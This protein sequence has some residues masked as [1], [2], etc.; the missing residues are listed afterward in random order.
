MNMQPHELSPEVLLHAY[1]SGMFPMAV[2]ELGNSI[3][4]FA[5]DPR[6]IIPLD[7][8]HVSKSLRR[9]VRKQPFEVVSDRDFEA[10]IRACAEPRE[11]DSQDETW[12]SEDIIKAY[13][14]L[15]RLGFAHSVECYENGE[16]VGGLYGVTLGG[17]FFGES[18]FHKATDASKIALYHLVKQM[19]RL[20]YQ[21][22]DVQYTTDHLTR[23]GAVEITRAEYEERLKAAVELPVV[24]S[25]EIS[26]G[27]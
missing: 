25:C 9:K 15:H 23:L 3:F 21:L 20:G 24:W 27:E 16:L 22:L 13:T 18:M 6:T 5:P 11:G 4:W 19:N 1:A 8:L 12:I 26:A 7:G 2:P 17:A 10:V 14:N